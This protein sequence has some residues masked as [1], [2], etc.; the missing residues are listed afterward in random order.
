MSCFASKTTIVASSGGQQS[1]Q[2]CDLI[3]AAILAAG[4]TRVYNL[5]NHGVGNAREAIFR[6]PPMGPYGSGPDLLMIHNS[7]GGSNG[8]YGTIFDMDMYGITAATGTSVTGSTGTWSSSVLFP[9]GGTPTTGTALGNN[10]DANGMATAFG[11]G[12]QT[13]TVRIICSEYGIMSAADNGTNQ[14]IQ[15]WARPMDDLR[16]PRDIGFQAQ[17]GALLTHGATI[18]FAAPTGAEHLSIEFDGVVKNVTFPTSAL[19]SYR[20]AQELTRQMGGLG[21]A[22]VRNLYPQV[23]GET[24]RVRKPPDMGPIGNYSTTRPRVRLLYQDPQVVA[25]GID[26]SLVSGTTMTAV[27]TGAGGTVQLS[28]KN[29]PVIGA[30]IGTVV[31]NR[32]RGNSANATGFTTTTNPMD[33]IV[34]D[35]VPGAWTA[36]DTYDVLPC[37]EHQDGVGS[38]GGVHQ[39]CLQSSPF[40]TV[41]A[42]ALR[43]LVLN[44][45]YGEAQGHYQVGQT[46]FFVNNGNATIITGNS[47]VAGMQIGA[48]ITNN[49][50]GTLGIVRAVDTGTNKVLIDTTAGAATAGTPYNSDPWVTGDSVTA[51][52]VTTTITGT[53]QHSGNQ[54]S[55]TTGWMGM[56]KVTAVSQVSATDPRTLLTIDLTALNVNPSLVLFPSFNIGVRSRFLLGIAANTPTSSPLAFMLPNILGTSISSNADVQRHEASASEM[57]NQPI[58][59]P[60]FETYSYQLG[61]WGAA[62]LGV[63][64]FGNDLIFGRLPHARSV[65]A[66]NVVP[67][68]GDD[69]QEDQD[70]NRVWVPVGQIQNGLFGAG[71]QTNVNHW[72]CQGPGAI[73]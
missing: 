41:A 34:L 5:H 22:F 35:T 11:T 70:A 54:G 20:I 38:F 25:A 31:Y 17:Q 9:A 21:E 1:A 4:G 12:A 15:V 39:A 63:G 24:V 68:I 43:T 69:L 23:Q 61:E 27:V 10:G 48:V 66:K 40:T 64:A 29:F 65:N 62:P 50:R 67:A 47:S 13:W 57:T 37:Q 53:V 26:F 60:D 56:A 16:G 58:H 44:D 72:L 8:Q 59:V 14:Y 46:V 51:N 7:N 3:A 52:G 19:T 30:R 55:P 28:T 42:G 32:T 45:L 6:M 49:T 18:T 71:T 36:G 73:P 2:W 33:T